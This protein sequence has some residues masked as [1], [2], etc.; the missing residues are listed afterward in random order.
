MP[1]FIP[2]LCFGAMI[3]LSLGLLGGGGSILTVPILIYALGQDARAAVATSL[4]IVG[5]NAVVGTMLHWRAGHVQ[6]RQ[7]L[8]FGAA[9]MAGAYLSAGF[10]HQVSDELLLVLFAVLMLVIGGLMVRPLT[11]AHRPTPAPDQPLWQRL[12]RI[13][14]VGAGVGALTGFLGVGGGFLIVPALVLVL[15]MDMADAVGSSLLVIGLNSVAGLAGHLQAG[16]L[17]WGLVGLFTVAG[18]LG[19]LMGT[20]WSHHWP[21]QRLR[22]AFAGLVL[23]LALVL[24]MLNLPVLLHWQL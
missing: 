2:A 15:G 5:A 19:L 11:V 1:F 8:V 20:R 13:L 10:S 12:G 7:A 9:G 24:L 4:A 3:G 22:R 17:N 23:S 16:N 6:V 14:I 18:V 21:A